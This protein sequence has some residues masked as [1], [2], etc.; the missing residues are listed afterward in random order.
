MGWSDLRLR[1]RAVLLSRRMEA[2]LEE[3]IGA[4]LELQIRKHM[5]AGASADRAKELAHRDFGALEN[6]KE[7]CRDERRTA[8]FAGLERDLLYAFRML[9]RSPGVA[10]LIVLMLGLGIGANV[11]TFSVMDAI[12]LKM[13]PVRQPGSLFRMVGANGSAYDAGIVISYKAFRL[14]RE[15][16]HLLADLMAYRPADEQAVSIKDDEQL[17]LTHQSVSGNYFPLLGVQPAFGRLI[18]ATDDG[19]PGQQ[20]VAVI[21]YRL[22]KDKFNTSAAAIGSKIHLADRTFDVIGIVPPQ[23]FGVEIGRIVDVWTPIAM[24]PLEYLQND[25]LFWL[26]PMG[27]LHAGVTIARAAAPMQAVMNEFMLE[28]VRQHAP[29][30]TPRSVIDRFLAGMKIKGAPAGGGIS[31]LRQQYKKPFELLIALAAVVLLIACTNAANLILARGTAR[32]QEIAIR[33]A[34]GSGRRRIFQQLITESLLLGLAATALGVLF[35]HWATPILARMLTPASQP[36]ELV[37]GFDLRLLI[38]TGCIALI[39]AVLSGVLPCFRLTRIDAFATLKSGMRLVGRKRERIKKVL[40]ASQIALSF[41]LVIGAILFG[42][43]LLNLLSLQLGFN[44]ANVLVTR[45]TLPRPGDEKTMFP[46]AWGDLLRRVQAI[47]GVEEASLASATLFDGNAPVVGVRTNSSQSAPADPVTAIL[48]VSADYFKTLR[49]KFVQGRDFGERDNYPATPAIAVV[50][51]AFA[52]KFFGLKSS[53]GHKLTKLADSPLWTE[54]VGIVR[55]AKFANLRD[56]ASP[57]IYV[58]YGRMPS[59]LSAQGHAGFAMSLQIRG[60]QE[61][62]TLFAALRREAGPR[63]RVGAVAQQQQ[64]IEDTLTRERLIAGV[65]SLAGALSLLLATL[66]LYGVMNYAVV[67]RRKEIGIRMALGAAPLKILVLISRESAAVVIAGI[68]T[69][70]VMAAFGTRLAKAMLYGL[71]PDAPAAFVSAAL[72]LLTASL[73]AAL[74]PAYKAATT[75]PMITLRNE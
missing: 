25:H 7:Q 66:G 65:A 4:H 27:R 28:D 17:R 56:A 36:A 29:P 44:P 50:N 58:P 23:F 24:A 11:A 10:A 71:A 12:L 69:G 68:G 35:A 41:M 62:S 60:R 42:R 16:T 8:W 39:T 59:W 2:E 19:K 52:R 14:M 74:V 31:Y 22:W 30:G 6:T 33:L 70:V 63:F 46:A 26:Q 57:T 48:F 75:D 15:R 54:I 34:L 61:P 20:P 55:D 38:F 45:L 3:E 1:V 67:Q 64:L 5:Q 43:T 37:I 47:P 73:I 49:I 13:L 18:A 32:Q 9:R 51:Q 72:I 21:S 53:I 40:V